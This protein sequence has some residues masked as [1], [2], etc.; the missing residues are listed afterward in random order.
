MY[1]RR[2]N[3][4]YVQ[5]LREGTIMTIGSILREAVYILAVIFA[6]VQLMKHT[7]ET[8]VAIGYLALCV[9]LV[10]VFMPFVFSAF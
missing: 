3:I 4:G 9:I 5:T 7:R 2:Y 10:W 6:I 8:L 1:G